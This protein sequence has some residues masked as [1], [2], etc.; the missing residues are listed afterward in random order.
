MKSCDSK[1]SHLQRPLCCGL[2]LQ[3]ARTWGPPSQ[4]CRSGPGHPPGPGAGNRWTSWWLEEEEKIQKH[5]GSSPL[6]SLIPPL[7]SPSFQSSASFG[8]VM[9]CVFVCVWQGGVSEV[10]CW[11]S[12]AL[13]KVCSLAIKGRG[14]GF[15]VVEQVDCEIWQKRWTEGGKMGQ[16]YQTETRPQ[17]WPCHGGLGKKTTS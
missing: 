4:V 14:G 3:I 2:S 17:S 12:G 5:C 11:S 9:D 10:C 13:K 7:P 16:F 6:L 15:V 1:F 8:L